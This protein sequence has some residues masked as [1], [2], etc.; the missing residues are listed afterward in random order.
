MSKSKP[1]RAIFAIFPE[2]EILDLAGPLQVLHEANALGADYRIVYAGTS[3]EI[4][5]EQG[6][7]ISRLEALPAIAPGDLVLVPGSPAFQRR[8][9][10]RDVARATGWL[11]EAHELGA[12]I[13]SIC[14][15][16][17]LLG[18]ARLLDHRTCTTH[19][20]HA[21]AL[22]TRFPKA[23]VVGN[24]LYVAD[25]RVVT[26]AGI[27][28]GIDMTLALVERTHGARLAADVA[29]AMVVYVRRDG[30]SAQKSVYLQHRD[31][32]EPSVHVVQDWL[33]DHAGESYTLDDLA[34]IAGLSRRHFTRVF[35]QATGIGVKE[36][37]TKLRLER[38]RLFL[39]DPSL[40]ID[41]IAERCG[42]ADARQL[43]RLWKD[44]YGTSPGADRG[45]HVS[46]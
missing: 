3:Q 12:T 18:E 34:A 16:A 26:S 9:Q 8:T 13:A 37:A 5:T 35:R 45:Y 38:A 23:N 20:S 11:R 41:T 31:H 15:G 7:H 43:R 22:Q 44:A 28:S 25:G 21:A 30:A 32:L 29:R 4:A 1:S 46:H 10:V 2:T 17:F 40:T 39:R 33:V 19:W 6:L 36:Y 14:V 42:F 27:A 24:R